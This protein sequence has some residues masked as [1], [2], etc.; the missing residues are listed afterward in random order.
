[1]ISVRK[2]RL[3][4]EKQGSSEPPRD[5]C[6]TSQKPSRLAKPA[7]NVR[8]ERDK[9]V[10]KY[11]PLSP[12]GEPHDENEVR[13]GTPGRWG[14]AYSNLYTVGLFVLRLR[15]LLTKANQESDRRWFPHSIEIYCEDEVTGFN[16]LMKILAVPEA[17]FRAYRTVSIRHCAVGY[18]DACQAAGM[19]W[20]AS[21]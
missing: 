4:A 21:S 5:D 15:R 7:A 6:G 20:E 10:D 9:K 8:G 3:R 18:A 16:R 2:I 14:F 12:R 13:R 19:R 11:T 17:D 1:M